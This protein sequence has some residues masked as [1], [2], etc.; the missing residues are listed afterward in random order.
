MPAEQKPAS[1]DLRG[2]LGL[3]ALAAVVILFISYP[4]LLWGLGGLFVLMVVVGIAGQRRTTIGATVAAAGLTVAIAAGW[5]SV[6]ACLLASA[7]WAVALALAKKF[8]VQGKEGLV[9]AI[10]RNGLGVALVVTAA[11]GAVVATSYWL[12]IFPPDH[13]LD[14]G[15]KIEPW[16]DRLEKIATYASVGMSALG[17]AYLWLARKARAT[18]PL[19]PAWNAAAA[20]KTWVE[21]GA[22]AL[23]VVASFTF[24][25]TGA[26]NGPIVELTHARA[27]ALTN[28]AD[29]VWKIRL[30]LNREI[31]FQVV[32]AA[33]EAAPQ[34]VQAAVVQ[35]A[36]LDSRSAQIPNVYFHG[37]TPPRQ[38]SEQL[39]AWFDPR[40]R[41]D[42]DWAA[43]LRE[44]GNAWRERERP[45]SVTPPPGSSLREIEKGRSEV[46][47]AAAGFVPPKWLT[48]PGE[49]VAR[50]LFDFATPTDALPVLKALGDSFPL[51][52]AIVDI[53]L[54]AS[55]EVLFGKLE[56][57]AVEIARDAMR[58]G[59]SSIPGNLKRAA[60]EL[61]P[62]LPEVDWREMGEL[63]RDLAERAD[64]VAAARERL[65]SDLPLAIKE[66][67]EDADEFAKKM[68]DLG[69]AEPSAA[70]K[71][72]TTGDPAE[73][74]PAIEDLRAQK[75][76]LDASRESVVNAMADGRV[77]D[78]KARDLLGPEYEP[79]RS[80]ADEVVQERAAAE[81]ARE[82]ER[83]AHEMEHEF[84]AP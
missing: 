24:T 35:E 73:G 41:R 36:Q 58:D 34:A 43:I 79:L 6:L 27:E 16:K 45:A 55:K 63:R 13:I 62:P 40:P 39:L 60:Q 75:K 23:A 4:V 77:P 78:D 31:K 17:V 50:G 56:A 46:S 68:A 76:R 61:A 15:E 54:D 82:A 67:R 30:E 64:E 47:R 44:A 74:A 57:P 29:L 51:L 49:D 52:S 33:Y 71:V 19:A 72:E 18:A 2:C 28:Y 26:A 42:S 25:A 66:V 84:H 53:G 14:W 8:L 59:A 5:R 20:V 10:V 22:L 37:E 12:S 48:G 1:H 3:V 81:R 21:R 65:E 83:R 70:K 38:T 7:M 69:I 32:A 80:R 9:P 11:I